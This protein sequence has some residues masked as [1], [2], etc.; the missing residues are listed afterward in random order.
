MVG[1]YIKCREFKQVR[2]FHEI[3]KPKIRNM[4]RF[5]PVHD[6]LFHDDQENISN[7]D[8]RIKYGNNRSFTQCFMDVCKMSQKLKGK[9]KNFS[10][11]AILLIQIIVSRKTSTIE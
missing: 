2:K 4:M 8:G 1:D 6:L 11:I 7:T 10:K 5:R 3:Y 9:T